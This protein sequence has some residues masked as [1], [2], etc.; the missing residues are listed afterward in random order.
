VTEATDLLTELN[1]A[2][3]HAEALADERG[4]PKAGSGPITFSD[5]D[6]ADAYDRVAGISAKLAALYR[7]SAT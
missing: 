6:V 1:V 7:G 5:P 4:V 2:L 3:E